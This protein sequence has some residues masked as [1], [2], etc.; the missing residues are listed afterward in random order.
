MPIYPITIIIGASLI[1][2]AEKISGLNAVEVSPS[3]PII[4]KN[5]RAINTK[6]HNNIK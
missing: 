1:L 4:I 2:L 3:P 5:P 6:L